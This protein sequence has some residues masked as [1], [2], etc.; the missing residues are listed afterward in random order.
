MTMK[1]VQF[2]WE[3]EAVF[4]DDKCYNEAEH[5]DVCTAKDDN[6]FWICGDDSIAYK[7]SIILPLYEES[8]IHPQPK[9][10]LQKIKKH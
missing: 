7:D 5:G 8:L 1:K 4:W 6:G 10:N 9:V 3:Q 2:I